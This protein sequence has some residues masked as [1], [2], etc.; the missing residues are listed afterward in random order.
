[1]RF[2][3]Q[4]DEELASLALQGSQEAFHA[5]VD[6]HTNSIYRLALSITGN[7]AEAEDIVQ[8]T[9]L[10]VFKHL[11]SFSAEKASFRSWLLT[12]AR[13]QSINVFGSIKRRA[14]KFFSEFDSED[15]SSGG[16]QN[17]FQSDQIDAESA[18]SSK[19]QFSQVNE[20]LKKLSE[21][22]RTA[23]LLKAQDNFSYEEIA[24]IM[25][26][27]ASSVESLIFRARRKLVEILKK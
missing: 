14:L 24:G 26:T 7:H 19:Q 18:L 23:L 27:T 21:R 10:R 8:E 13:N 17:F 15:G 12:I 1:M 9:F 11:T 3:E 16:F 25:E 5:L 6:R 22:Q 4:T 20:A 2:S